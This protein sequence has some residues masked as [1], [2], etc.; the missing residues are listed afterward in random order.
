MNIS[1]EKIDPRT[2]PQRK[3][4]T[5]AMMPGVGSGTFGFRPV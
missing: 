3:L 4:Y 2:V 5:G 1:L